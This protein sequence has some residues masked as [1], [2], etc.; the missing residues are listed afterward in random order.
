[1]RIRLYLDE[2][3]MDSDLTESLRSRGI[4]V[5]TVRDEHKQGD[6]DEQQ[7]LHASQ[8]GRVL[9]S[10][11][12]RDFMILHTRTLEQGLSHAGIIL[13]A[14]R[15]FSIGEQMRR[16]VRLIDTLSAEDMQN[17]VEFLSAWG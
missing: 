1:V 11:N 5:T 14:K 8:E 2:D 4:D 17:R 6:S 16:L 7:L 15:R 12:T 3:A 10:F 13:V 9:Y